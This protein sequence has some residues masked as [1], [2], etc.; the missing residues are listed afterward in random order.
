MPA[1]PT[2]PLSTALCRLDPADIEWRVANTFTSNGQLFGVLVPYVTARVYMDR[3]DQIDPAWSSRLVADP[4][5]KGVIREL[6][7]LGVTRADAGGFTGIEAMKGAAS[8]SLKRA[9]VLFGIGRELYELPKIIAK[10]NEKK[11]P[12]GSPRFVDGAWR[13]PRG[14]RVLIDQPDDDARPTPI[15]QA[16]S[17]RRPDDRPDG[18]DE[19]EDGAPEPAQP[20]SRRAEAIT[21]IKAMMDRIEAAE[22]ST[23][24]RFSV[25]A[26]LR[27]E[28]DLDNLPMLY[29]RG[30]GA[31]LIAMGRYIAEKVAELE[32]GEPEKP[33]EQMDPDAAFAA[34]A[35]LL[36]R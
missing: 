28:H 33:A 31:Q 17:Q 16:R 13:A 15:S 3:F 36:D 35:A 20:G 18:A 12:I 4:N 8:D 11:Q 5:G 25:R 10:L 9:G 30:T 26:H 1:K 2:L 29:A 27:R 21:K 6:T 34:G 32:S 19:A 22:S 24:N 14:G 7:L 23:V